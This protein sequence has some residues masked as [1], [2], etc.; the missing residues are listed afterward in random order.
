[1]V[2]IDDALLN[3]A[4]SVL[5]SSTMK[6]TVNWS[7]SEVVAAEQRRRHADRLASM[8]GLELDNPGVMS[9]AWR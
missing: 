2:D 3:E 9:Q 1:L 6:E 5:G 8:S 7:L 4:K